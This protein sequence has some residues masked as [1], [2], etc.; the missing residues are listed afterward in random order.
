MASTKRIAKK[1]TKAPAPKKQ[2]KPKATPNASEATRVLEAPVADKKLKKRWDEAIGRYRD[3]L[4]NATAGWDAR[5][6]ALGEI[7][8][9]DPPYYL[10][11]GYKTANAFL[12]AEAPSEDPRTVRSYIRVAKHFDPV[13]EANYG[14]AKLDL[15]IVYLTA[16]AGKAPEGKVDPEACR[17]EVPKGSKRESLPLSRV[18]AEDLRRATRALTSPSQGQSPYESPFVKKLRAVLAK[19]GLSS[20]GVAMRK[21]LVTLSGIEKGALA[22]LG[23]A[24]G[25]MRE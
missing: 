1:P 22:K 24:L 21:E 5:Y 12:E 23:K 16:K 11:A 19:A 17:I 14:I 9:A 10:A 15:L 3:A 8:D 2:A 7:M 13:D 6:E 18:T 25:S 4:T 20:V